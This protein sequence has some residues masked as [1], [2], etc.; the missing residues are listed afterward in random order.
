MSRQKRSQANRQV[1][2]EIKA[3]SDPRLTDH[4]LAV[5]QA[6]NTPDIFEG[7]RHKYPG[8]SEI[9]IKKG[10]KFNVGR[11]DE[12]QDALEIT[13]NPGS[14]RQTSQQFRKRFGKKKKEKQGV[15]GAG[16]RPEITAF[17]LQQV[18]PQRIPEIPVRTLP[19]QRTTE[20]TY[21]GARELSESLGAS[22]RLKTQQIEFEARHTQWPEIDVPEDVSRSLAYNPDFSV[23]T[24]NV[25]RAEYD[26]YHVGS[27]VDAHGQAH[28]TTLGIPVRS[29]E[30]VNLLQVKISPNTLTH[31]IGYPFKH[32]PDAEKVVVPV[33]GEIIGENGPITDELE[34][35]G[36]VE[37]VRTSEGK[38]V[39]TPAY[40][41]TMRQA[42]FPTTGQVQVLEIGGR[43][44]IPN[45]PA[46]M[47]EAWGL[48]HPQGRQLLT[49]I[50]G[51]AMQTAYQS[52]GEGMDYP[53]FRE[54]YESSM[55]LRAGRDFLVEMKNLQES[56]AEGINLDLSRLK[57]LKVP[58]CGVGIK[59]VGAQVYDGN[60]V[61]LKP[62]GA[63][64]I[65]ENMRVKKMGE[66]SAFVVDR[67]LE[68]SKGII[69]PVAHQQW[70]G[71]PVGGDTTI[72]FLA[73]GRENRLLKHGAELSYITTGV[74]PLLSKDD[75]PKLTVP[76]I[77]VVSNLVLD[78]TRRVGDIMDEDYPLEGNQL[79]YKAIVTEKYVL[80]RPRKESDVADHVERYFDT[81][82]DL[83]QSRLAQRLGKN[84]KA[85]FN[86]R[87]TVPHDQ[88]LMGNISLEG[89]LADTLDLAPM[90]HPREFH[91]TILKA[92]SGM[93]DLYE[94]AGLGADNYFSSTHFKTLLNESLG[95]KEAENIMRQATRLFQEPEDPDNTKKGRLV[96]A[97]TDGFLK[98]AGI[99]EDTVW[100]MG[101]K[102]FM[103]LIGRD[104]E[105]RKK[106]GITRD[107]L[108][109]IR[110]AHGK[111]MPLTRRHKYMGISFT[112]PHQ[113]L[114]A[115]RFRVDIIQR[116]ESA[117]DMAEKNQWLKDRFK[118]K[119]GGEKVE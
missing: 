54:K 19:V 9:R 66:N 32:D 31:M 99:V 26:K 57:I 53:E 8:I 35:K 55:T 88:D 102:D 65:T 51:V 115:F 47:R 108:T 1:E 17:P 111:G 48:I 59:G 24:R 116:A 112:D 23:P 94:V 4:A 113:E 67:R 52:R 117:M 104:K 33:V 118:E 87:L 34:Q 105:I 22:A 18:S 95:E 56:G 98:S 58:V 16:Q 46:S 90:R 14:S 78:D 40:I 61:R 76:Q 72:N 64:D 83:H 86:A 13:V 28:L 39:T 60:H 109:A 101:D 10:K 82:R 25:L 96:G 45:S 77:A 20:G 5:Q 110:Q 27:Y 49:E 80:E 15:S 69:C 42:Q 75:Y 21:P 92:L 36:I 71:V 70:S 89:G 100:D 12:K 29:L 74:I 85:L 11:Y 84:L 114:E 37:R 62:N 91:S 81:A 6:A 107:S 43:K 7:L 38:N 103:D 50:V 119:Y 97:V 30:E 93:A 44:I 106:L 79:A 41:R 2:T 73:Y 3:N 63:A 68:D